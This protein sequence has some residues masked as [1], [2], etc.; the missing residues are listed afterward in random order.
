MRLNPKSPVF[1][2]LNH[3][4]SSP[5]FFLLTVLSNIDKEAV[6]H[7]ALKGKKEEKKYGAMAGRCGQTDVWHM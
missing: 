1:K 7:S 5:V 2:P 3:R 4:C 6:C